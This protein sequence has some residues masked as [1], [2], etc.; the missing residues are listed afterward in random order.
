VQI[1]ELHH[2]HRLAAG[3]RIAEEEV[4]GEP[5][6][7]EQSGQLTG[8]GGGGVLNAGVLAERLA[9]DPAGIEQGLA[10]LGQADVDAE[11]LVVGI[12]LGLAAGGG[13]GGTRPL[14]VKPLTAGLP[15]VE[16]LG[17]PGG[18]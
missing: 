17:G 11:Q 8:I 10:V 14:A 6:L 12:V 4:L 18:P 2:Q 9:L 3:G 5:P 13:A 7:I 15:R 1:G 16:I